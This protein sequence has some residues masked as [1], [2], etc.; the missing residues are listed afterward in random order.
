MCLEVL[1]NFKEKIFVIIIYDILNV[2]GTP[3]GV[4]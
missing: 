2:K 4:L 1:N 3:N